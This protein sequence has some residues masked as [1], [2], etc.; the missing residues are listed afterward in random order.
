MQV[1]LGTISAKKNEELI[2]LLSSVRLTFA[3]ALRE[4]PKK[5]GA[6]SELRQLGSF[7]SPI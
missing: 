2:N 3:C 6:M 4:P 1:V 5:P 7:W